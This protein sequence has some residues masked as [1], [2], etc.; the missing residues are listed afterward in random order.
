MF[1]KEELTNLLALINR[2]QITGQEAI[3]VAM[4]QQKISGLIQKKEEPEEKPKNEGKS[5]PQ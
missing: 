4:L 1:T 5:K 3:V 2:S